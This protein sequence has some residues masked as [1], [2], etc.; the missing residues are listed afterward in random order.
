MFPQLPCQP[1]QSANNTQNKTVRNPFIIAPGDA[2]DQAPEQP[3]PQPR[4][5]VEV[6]LNPTLI[7]NFERLRAGLENLYGRNNFSVFGDVVGLTIRIYSFAA[8]SA[9]KRLQAEGYLRSETA[10]TLCRNVKRDIQSLGWVQM[11]PGDRGHA[12]LRLGGKEYGLT[13]KKS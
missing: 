7:I 6:S 11:K 4:A 8:D 3:Q 9:V 2:T 1:A 12:V 5:F 13:Y 10:D